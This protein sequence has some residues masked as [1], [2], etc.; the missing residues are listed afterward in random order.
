MLH[1]LR[2]AVEGRREA[3]A[4]AGPS[5]VGKTFLVESL[6]ELLAGHDIDCVHLR[7]PQLSPRE[8]LSWIAVELGCATRSELRPADESL[9]AIEAELTNRAKSNR[10]TLLVVDEAQLLD[11]LGLFETLRLVT[12][13][14]HNRQPL[15]TLLM[16]GQ[17]E[18]LSML[19]RQP[20]FAQRVAQVALLTPL[21]KRETRDYV[22]GRF[23]A[24]GATTALTTNDGLETLYRLSEGVPRLINRL[25]DLALVV[26]FAE[27][28]AHLDGALLDSVAGELAMLR[29]A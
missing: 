19:G 24:A 28:A 27:G 12:N 9:H 29:A 2:Y 18:L 25:M 5:G 7:F 8:L 14:S 4:L 6:A 22:T 13:L 1:K 16:V 23:A 26:G 21:S 3:V 15:S 17:P 10:H 20:A 11:D